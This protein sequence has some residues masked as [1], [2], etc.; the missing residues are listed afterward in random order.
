MESKKS[1]AQDSIAFRAAEELFDI[2]VQFSE[3]FNGPGDRLVVFDIIRHVYICLMYSSFQGRALVP[4]GDEDV[5]FE[6]ALAGAVLREFSGAELRSLL[7]MPERLRRTAL[8]KNVELM[9]ECSIMR[10][11]VPVLWHRIG[12]AIDA[13]DTNGMF[14]AAVKQHMG[15]LRVK[16]SRRETHIHS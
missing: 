6:R 11:R 9:R 7:P 5:P 13:I 12:H 4:W 8:N 2:V 16:F 14:D 15:A 1:P 10:D 3:V